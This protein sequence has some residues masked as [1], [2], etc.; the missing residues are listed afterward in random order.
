MICM[1][2]VL[3]LHGLAL[4]LGHARRWQPV[5]AIW[6]L[7]ATLLGHQGVDCGVLGIPVNHN[8]IARYALEHRSDFLGDAAAWR[9]GLRRY[10]FQTRK[11]ELA[12]A[13]LGDRLGRT[14][15]YSLALTG[16]SHPV[17]N[18]PKVLAPVYLVDRDPSQELRS[19]NRKRAQVICSTRRQVS[20]ARIEPR[21]GVS[22][23]KAVTTPSHPSADRRH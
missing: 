16:L 21:L 9:V 8:A 18:V 17:A 5:R 10:D 12:K 3:V 23:C 4:A 22:K 15:C 11:F 6:R 13:V 2:N 19:I 7:E 1:P 14:R 20:I